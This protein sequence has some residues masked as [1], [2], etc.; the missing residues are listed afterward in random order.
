MSSAAW[1]WV[2]AFAACACTREP[3]TESLRFDG[4][5]HCRYEVFVLRDRPMQL[6]VT[7]SCRGRG[8][9]GLRASR[10]E[11]IAGLGS[12]TSEQGSVTRRERTFQLPR[13]LE[14]V[15]FRYGLDLDAV[16]LRSDSFD[17]ALRQGD[18]ILLPVSTLLLHPLPLDVGTEIELR[19]RT[20]KGIDYASGLKWRDDIQLLEAHEIPTATYAIFGTFDRR[21]VWLDEG[22]AR[23]DLATLGALS[24]SADDLADWLLDRARAVS[25]FYGGFPA[26]RGLVAVVSVPGRPGVRFGNILPESAPGIL[27]LLGEDTSKAQL[28]SDWILLHELLHIGV[29]S[30]HAEGKW[31]DEGLATYFEP[32][33]RARAGLLSER[34]VWAKFATRLPSGL[35]AL[36]QDG[37]E[38]ARGFKGLYW[39]GALFC[40]LADVAVRKRSSGRLGLEDGLRRVRAAGGHASEV[41]QLARTLELADSA[42]QEP[43]LMPLLERYGNR[44]APLD[45]DGLLTDLGVL[46]QEEGLKLND[47][48]P[49]AWVRSALVKG[50]PRSVAR[51]PALS[52]E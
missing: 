13:P 28:S 22:A 31:F 47:D 6:E 3:R 42:F 8:I 30:F 23:L 14:R 26:E 15:T 32:I 35:G 18:A 7:A 20:P 34:D 46:G 21:S 41:W 52:A 16:A 11:T 39:G 29:P 44:P 33:V 1:L 45:L 5:D 37:L 19:V 51:E 43:V 10:F 40:L 9:R 36:T 17:G 48:A 25:K 50:S 4:V 2:G 27:L 12:V 24:V 38:R 49:L